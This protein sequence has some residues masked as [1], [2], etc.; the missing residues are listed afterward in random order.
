MKPALRFEGATALTQTYRQRTLCV[1]LRPS[2]LPKRVRP[3]SAHL[4]VLGS[5]KEP[6]LAFRRSPELLAAQRRERA[7]V[8]AEKGRRWGRPASQGA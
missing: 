5:T 2:W 1:A 6:N 8:R 4:G 7:R 3:T